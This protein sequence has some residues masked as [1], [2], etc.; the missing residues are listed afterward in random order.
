VWCS[1]GGSAYCQSQY[2]DT[3]CPAEDLMNINSYIVDAGVV[4]LNDD[5][6]VSLEYINI[7]LRMG[8]PVTF[9]VTVKASNDFPLDLYILM[10]NS[11]SFSIFLNTFKSLASTLPLSL[12][13][14]SSSAQY[15][16]GMFVDK[17]TPPYTSQ[18]QLLRPFNFGIVTPFSYQHVVNLTN[19]SVIFV[20]S[21]NALRSSSNIDNPEG[22]L[23]AMMQAVVC[24]DVIGWREKSRKI[25]LVITDDVLHTAGDG[26]LAFINKPNDGLCHTQFN[27]ILN[28]TMYTDSLIQDYP[29]VLQ[30]SSKL[31]EEGIIP[32]FAIPTV[33][34]LFELYR[35]ITNITGG[36]T[37]E[38]TAASTNII[39]AINEA[40]AELVS[41]AQ[42]NFDT[43]SHLSVSV[44][45]NCSDYESN[46]RKCSNIVNETV[47]FQIT[48]V[49][50]ECTPNLIQGGTDVIQMDIPGFGRFNMNVNGYCSCQCEQE[51]M[52]NSNSCNMNGNETCGLCTCREGWNRSDCS[53]ST[54]KCPLGPNGNECSGRGTCECG[55]CT[56]YSPTISVNGII[57]P[58]I[59]GEA[60]ECSNFD[61]TTNS[62]NGLVC[63]GRGDCM[64]SNGTFTCHC[65][66]SSSTNIRYTGDACQCSSDSCVNP[67]DPNRLICSGKGRCNPSC[68]SIEGGCTC[69]VGFAG[70]YC[71]NPTNSL[72]GQCDTNNVIEFFNCF[73]GNVESP[74][75]CNDIRCSNFI[76]LTNGTSQIN[77]TECQF[78]RG[79]CTYA[80][81]LQTID[82]MTPTIITT[83]TNGIDMTVI[84]TVLPN[85]M[86]YLPWV[87]G[88]VVL[89]LVSV[90]GVVIVITIKGCTVYFDKRRKYIKKEE[91]ND[92]QNPEVRNVMYGAEDDGTAFQ[93][94]DSRGYV[95]IDDP[96]ELKDDADPSNLNEFDDS[97]E[98]TIEQL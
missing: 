21:I 73:G 64:C 91:F 11:A 23:D 72:T 62:D 46:I 45:A 42:L 79:D 66:N 67:D 97:K 47:E 13:N 6:Q 31:T 35:T 49:L 5:N 56:C 68:L 2:D 39:N 58:Q 18:I 63:S 55:Q 82:T 25:L 24:T 1:T 22:T 84:P 85:D 37:V 59:F 26:S 69:N 19:D 8:E 57:N 40:Y 32:V 75:T 61:C 28:M 12:Q 51:V 10:D 88:S 41:R 77:P 15:G 76:P 48:L 17:P 78:I 33:N 50:N 53:C 83:T 81:S 60:C 80:Y 87:I 43:P 90:I 16:F 98:H 38:L 95:I 52:V 74:L 7:K 27:P 36:T 71:Q 3:N 94:E 34:D 20:A 93:A 14:I 29:S 9:N 89:V 4:P 54:A 92:E 30:V 86:A 65:Y 44:N 70:E 96:I